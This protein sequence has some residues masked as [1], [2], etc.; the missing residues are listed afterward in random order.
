MINLKISKFFTIKPLKETEQR[1]P[2][3]SNLLSKNLEGKVEIKC[4]RCKSIIKLIR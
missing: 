1:C 2:N 3:C 4:K